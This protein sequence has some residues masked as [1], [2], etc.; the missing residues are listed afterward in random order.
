MPYAVHVGHWDGLHGLFD[1]AYERFGR[2]DVL[3]NNAGKS[4]PYPS[5][6]S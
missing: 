2:V 5:A 1:A 3:I 6:D 4:P